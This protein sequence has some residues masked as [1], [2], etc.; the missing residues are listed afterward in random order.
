PFTRFLC[1]RSPTSQIRSLLPHS[2]P[3]PPAARRIAR[4]VARTM[5]PPTPLAAMLILPSA[6]SLRPRLGL[7]PSS[8]RARGVA[9]RALPGRLE[10]WHPRLAAVESGPPSSQSSAPP[11]Q[12]SSEL[13]GGMSGS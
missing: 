12:L 3:R 4:P 5:M 9:L 1:A 13:L 11:P 2:A 7:G 10:L 8:S 6:P